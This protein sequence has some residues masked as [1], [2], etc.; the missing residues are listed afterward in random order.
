MMTMMA[1]SHMTAE[2]QSIMLLAREFARQYGQQYIGTEHLLMAILGEPA[3]LGARALESLSVDQDGVKAQ[4]DLLLKARLHETWVM[5]RLPGTPHF[6]D[7]L[8]RA[9]DRAKG[10]QNWQI[11]SEH[12][13]LAI[14]EERNCTGCRVLEAL[15]ITL[16]TARAAVARIRQDRG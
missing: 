2:A 7:I 15:G 12:L 9:R 11:G 16:A 3:G 5:G 10:T 4:I 8:A 1:T 13:L 6:R 14:L